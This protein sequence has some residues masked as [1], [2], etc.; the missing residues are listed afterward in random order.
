MRENPQKYVL[1]LEALYK[2][3]LLLPSKPKFFISF[4]LIM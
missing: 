1:A 2:R 3:V 4:L